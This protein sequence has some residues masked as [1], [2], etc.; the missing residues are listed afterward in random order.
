MELMR[1][2]E[3]PSGPQDRNFYYSRFQALG[4]ALMLLAIA[5][6]LTVF[7]RL[8]GVWPAYF[9]AVFTVVCLL[10]YQKVVT[11]RFRP[12]NWLVR[13]TDGG[14]FIKFRSYLNFGFPDQDLTVAFIP[15]SDI[16]SARYVKERQELPSQDGQ[17]RGA[18]TVRTR[19]FID[20]ELAVNLEPLAT[21]L[22][23][24]TKRVFAKAIDGGANV[25]TRYQHLPVKGSDPILRIEWNVVPSAQVLLDALTRHTLV[26][27]A[28]KSAKDFTNLETLERKEQ[29]AR[30]LELAESGDIIAA[31][32]MARK[33]YAY[34]LTTAKEFIDSLI[35]K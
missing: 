32:A 8:N 9:V 2:A 26:Q 34:D 16:R 4:G 7:A 11:A 28:G 21:A 5:V 22:T 15:Y 33:L 1:A 19:R 29:E 23:H 17:A 13:M 6:G 12:T 25:S 14:L 27:P 20:L 18:P 3:V 10:I 31:V 35:R 24:E 30:L